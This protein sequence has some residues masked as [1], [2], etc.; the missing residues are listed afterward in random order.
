MHAAEQ[1]LVPR[2]EAAV[3]AAFGAEYG[4][5]DPQLRAATRPEFGHFQTNLPLRL[6]KSTALPA[7]RVAERLLAQ[8]R[9]DDL[10][11]PPALGGQGFINLTLR[12]EFLAAQV[13]ALLSDDLLGV[14][15]AAP[16]QRIVVDFSSPN[17]AKQMHVGHLRSTIIGDTLARVL[18]FVGHDVVRRN[19]VGDWGTQ[20]GML[21]EQL[22]DEGGDDGDLDLPALDALY[23][24]ARTRFDGDPAF[25]DRAR[26]RVVALQA[27]DGQTV[28]VW[29]RMV[30]VSLAGFDAMYARLGVRLTRAD[31]A[32]E[33]SYHDD[34]PRVVADLTEAGLLTRSEG[35]LCAFLPG[36]TNR[37]GA[38]LPLIVRKA[39]GGFGYDATD[40]AAI[41][42]R[43]DTLGA[44]R[45]VYVVD[46]RQSLHFDQVFALASA[47]GWLP[48]RVAAQHVGFGMV[49]GEDGKPFKTRS[50]DTVSL[51]SLLDAAEA[52][53]AALLDERG[54]TLTGP[55]RSATAR[56]IG[57]G[58]V[59]YA[60][61]AGGIGRDYVFA[62][63]RLVAL[64]G[65]TGPYLQYAH[66]RLASLLDRSG[67]VPGRVTML[68]HAAEQRLALLLTGFP[69]AVESVAATLEP[70]RLCG[71]L[72][73][74]ATALSVFYEECPVLR[75]SGDV[76]ASRLALCLAARRVLATGLD[77]LGITAL[78]RM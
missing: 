29:R 41:R 20:F 8:L 19:H 21:I 36:F 9:V 73:Q 7:P 46:V 38:P 1:A 42:H 43:I 64:A 77:L 4:G 28:G 35:A 60:D 3:V 23:R 51:A 11:L 31:V 49:L 24:R 34:L 27:G 69:G 18:S 2:L 66:A 54:S 10:C 72:Y 55:A 40:L 17:V 71:Y 68:D 61:L 25:A 62:L 6:A 22:L 47:A 65:N 58:A 26:A 30:A 39:D 37:D 32:G 12:P 5:W 78:E 44:D 74:V 70:H 63:D 75:A 48:T 57:V 45:L 14:R 16:S 50:G 67:G 33:S 59:K 56:A 53:A 15:P 52:K 76:R 13:N